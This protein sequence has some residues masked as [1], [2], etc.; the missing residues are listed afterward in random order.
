[1][2]ESFRFVVL[3][4]GGL[5]TLEVLSSLVSKSFHPLC[6]VQFGRE[7]LPRGSEF[8]GIDVEVN[9][10]S[11]ALAELL[12]K[13][14][15]PRYYASDHQLHELIRSLMVDFLLVACWPRL[16]SEQVT[17]EVHHAALNLHPSLLPSYRGFDPIGDQLA[18]GDHRFGITLH[19]L[20]QQYDRGDIVLQRELAVEGEPAAPLVLRLAAR[21]GA[22]LFTEAMQSYHKPGWK[23]VR[24]G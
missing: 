4:T 11:G 18:A 23:L 12:D 2:T 14:G 20:S 21:H 8:S 22:E 16:L 13:H 5:F 7:S 10:S 6:Y 19:L 17:R 9:A 24:Q 15:I 1:M 3:G